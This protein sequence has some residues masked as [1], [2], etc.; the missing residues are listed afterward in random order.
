MATSRSKKQA[1]STELTGGTGFTFED[2]VVAYYLAALLREEGAAGQ[3]GLVTSVAVQQSAYGHPLDDLVVDFTHNSSF[4]RLS[5]QLKRHVVIS[6]ATSNSAFRQII[7]ASQETC[8]AETFQKSIDTYGFAVEHVATRPFRALQRLIAWAKSSPT[9]AAFSDRFVDTRPAAAEERRL[10]NSLLPLIHGGSEDDEVSFYRQFTALDFRSLTDGGVLKTEIVNRLQE[11]VIS[12]NDHLGLLLFDRLCRIARV[13]A[14]TARRW[15]RHALLT[16]LHKQVR[17]KAIPRYEP[18]IDVLHTFSLVCMEDLSDDIDGFRVERL[19][20]EEK[21]LAQLTKCRLVNISGLPGCGKSAVLKRIA[22][23]YTAQGPIVF[24]KSD[25]LTGTSWLSFAHAHGLQTSDL[26]GLL[27]EIGSVGTPILFVD[28]IDRV[29]PDQKGIITD[30]LK[31]IQ[32]HE[33]L[34]KWKVIAT[35]RNQGLEAYRSWFPVAFYGDPG[36]GDVSVGSFSDAESETLANAKPSLARLLRGPGPARAIARQP[37]FASVLA[38]RVQDDPQSIETE[39]ELISAWWGGGGYDAPVEAV[40]ERQRALLD[41]AGQGVRTLGKSISSA[42][43]TDA[44]IR[45][46]AALKADCVIREHDDGAFFSFAHDIFFEW[47]FFRLLIQ[48]GSSWHVQLIEAGEPPLLGRVVGL[49]AQHALRSPGKWSETYR[50]LETQSLR[51]QWR[52]EWLTAPP[53]TPDF[54]TRQDEF[55]ALI[56]EDDY[57]VLDKML[58]W[59]QAQHTIPSPLIFAVRF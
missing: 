6:G 40:P 13:G 2:T 15:T 36:I 23:N 28:G 44:T 45:R 50:E 12:E 26:S 43:L 49:L 55:E 27:T 46:I 42:R 21:I 34:A 47:V 1:T 53:F 7:T 18:D 48:C 14:G 5:L 31:T 35:S 56:V 9:G 57:A 33:H 10:R 37:F 16:D 29:N 32:S 39:V 19:G 4:R 58:V 17:L 20:I 59:F 11:L 22:R 41:L 24:L 30:I 52:R 54:T 3:D 38:R 25:R 51:A 8:V